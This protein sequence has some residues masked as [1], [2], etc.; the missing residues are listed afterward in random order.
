M[1]HAGV[2]IVTALQTL[3]THTSDRSL[4]EATREVLHT[5]S[6]GGSLADGLARSPAIFQ[7]ASISLVSAGERAGIVCESLETIHSNL[8]SKRALQAR[9]IRAMTYPAIVL[10]TLA[11][12]VGFLLVWVI[13]T[14]EDLF[15]ETG[16]GLPWLTKLVLT[17]S[18]AVVEYWIAG[19]TAIIVV[20]SI[21]V[22][23]LRRST[24]AR[25]LWERLPFNIP[26]IRTVLMRRYACEF[27]TLMA[28]L[29]R[30]GIP[31]VQALE[32]VMLTMRNAVVCADLARTREDLHEGLSL[33]AAL[34]RSPILPPMVSQMVGIGETSGQLDEMLIKTGLMYRE[35]LD[36]AL[37]GMKQLAEPI[38]IVLIGIVVGTLILAIYLPIFQMGD[39]SGF[40]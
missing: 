11:L 33:S 16:V 29:L 20:L 28:A 1:L 6:Q 21:L 35:E 37:E 5:I 25:L 27:T 38:L 31:I 23:L 22:F 15:A 36:E 9:L 34:E 24:H 32:I 39:V 26:Y 2:P 13:P 17:T 14:F 10:L 12:V 8:E 3:E 30:A 40:R 4:Q 18:R 7:Q 19:V